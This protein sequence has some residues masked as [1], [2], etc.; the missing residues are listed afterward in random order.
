MVCAQP[1][2]GKFWEG[3]LQ[4]GGWADEEDKT[5]AEP[6]NVEGAWEIAACWLKPEFLA[7]EPTG[8]GVFGTLAY[9]WTYP[10][11]YV[12]YIS[13]FNFQFEYSYEGALHKVVEP[14]SKIFVVY[15]AK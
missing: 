7:V 13:A 10:H 11:R 1:L 3:G 4:L 6:P 2:W 9:P 8:A 12:T 5:G 14:S 15:L